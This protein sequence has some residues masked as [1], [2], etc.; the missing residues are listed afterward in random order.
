M[1][2]YSA[3]IDLLGRCAPEMHV[4]EMHLNLFNMSNVDWLQELWGFE[5]KHPNRHATLALDNAEPSGVVYL[6]SCS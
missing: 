4:S 1:S 6:C 3:L 5:S 2:F